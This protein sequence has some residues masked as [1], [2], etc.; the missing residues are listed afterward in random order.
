MKDCLPFKILFCGV[1][2]ILAG[3][4][5]LLALDDEA[6]TSI[7]L[8][9]REKSGRVSPGRV[10]VMGQS[11]PHPPSA[12]VVPGQASHWVPGETPLRSESAGSLLRVF[13]VTCSE[14][15]GLF[16]ADCWVPSLQSI[17]LLSLSLSHFHTRAPPLRFRL[18]PRA[19][20]FGN[21][22]PTHLIKTRLSSC[23]SDCPSAASP[24]PRWT[25]LAP[26]CVCPPHGLLLYKRSPL[27]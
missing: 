5:S 24:P 1:N 10:G 27:I 23:W 16:I 15:N 20:C 4:L 21:Q 12:A 9:T 26:T 7:G 6:L 2:F 8:P 3:L 17:K 14:S 13:G 18:L 11:P 25:R 19:H 22:P